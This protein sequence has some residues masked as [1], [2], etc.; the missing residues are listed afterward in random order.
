MSLETELN[1]GMLAKQ[2][3]DSVKASLDLIRENLH[4]E[5][6]QSKADDL[7]GRENAWR[8]LKAV[9]ELERSYINKINTGKL[10]S[11]SLEDK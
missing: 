10:A 8:M 6:E 11:K 4:K 5:W 2:V 3:L 9:N 7:D 1:E